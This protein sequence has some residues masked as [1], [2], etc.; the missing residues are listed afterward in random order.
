ML[1]LVMSF[2]FRHD[3]EGHAPSLLYRAQWGV[4]CRPSMSLF[5]FQH[6]EEV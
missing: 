5:Q 4:V 6:G 3:E 1:L 2:S